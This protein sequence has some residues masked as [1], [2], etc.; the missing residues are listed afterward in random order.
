[1]TLLQRIGR[2]NQTCCRGPADRPSIGDVEMCRRVEGCVC[3]KTKG[4]LIVE[5]LLTWVIWL[6][7]KNGRVLCCSGSF[8]VCMML[9]CWVQLLVVE[10]YDVGYCNGILRS[11]LQR[12]GRSRCL[13]QRKIYC[14]SD[15][16]LLV[17]EKVV[18]CR[19]ISRCSLQMVVKLL[20]VMGCCKGDV[21]LVIVRGRVVAETI[22]VI[23]SNGCNY[24][25][26]SSCSL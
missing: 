4:M 25:R 12:D 3:V 14:S 17:R 2:L 1:M 9:D 15:L 22:F 19:Q 11:S 5:G 20:N 26:I 8:V 24:L 16:K 13:L 6:L 10:E 18:Y 23:Y 21:K 7:Q